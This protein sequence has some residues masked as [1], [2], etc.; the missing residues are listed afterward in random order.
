M[1]F[2][3]DYVRNKDLVTGVYLW[4]DHWKNNLRIARC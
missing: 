2:F 1:K 3:G 4:Q